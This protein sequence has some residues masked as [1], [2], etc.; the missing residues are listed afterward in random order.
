MA[1]SPIG[2]QP[3][4][5]TVSPGCGFGLVDRLHAH[6]RGL[7][8]GGDRP[9]ASGRAP[10]KPTTLGRLADEEQRGEAPFAGPAAHTPETPRRPGGRRRDHRRRC[11]TPRRRPTRRCRPARDPGAWGGRSAPPCVRRTRRSHRSRRRRPGRVRHGARGRARRSRRAG[12][13]WA[14]APGS[15]SSL[16][17][18]GGV[19]VGHRVGSSHAAGTAGVRSL[20][21]EAVGFPHGAC[22]VLAVRTPRRASAA[23]RPGQGGSGGEGVTLPSD[24]CVCAQS[25][26]WT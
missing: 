16:S 7:G 9:A 8:Q 18:T 17:P 12:R 6:R 1:S 10:G 20:R 11:P 3:K 22:G 23:V 4:T 13:R 5:A 2:P 14:R 26:A 25:G 19:A 24:R 21:R 15:V